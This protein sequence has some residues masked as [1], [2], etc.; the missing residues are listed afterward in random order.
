VGTFFFKKT[1]RA[2]LHVENGFNDAPLIARPT[3]NVNHSKKQPSLSTIFKVSLLN[4]FFFADA[5][6]CPNYFA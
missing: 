3:S 1:L 2:H 6:K 5:L 4:Q